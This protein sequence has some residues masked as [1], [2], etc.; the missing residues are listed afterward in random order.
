MKNLTGILMGFMAWAVSVAA[1]AAEPTPAAKREIQY[2]FS[3]LEGSGCQFYRNGTW[4]SVNEASKHLRQKYQAMLD[5]GL[6]STA[7]SFID[8]GA[9]VSS[10]SGNPYQVRCAGQA[11]PENSATWFAAALARQRQS[12]K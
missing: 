6:I 5:R 4:Y 11:K 12:S 9:S 3:H 8:K 7:E 1:L 2:L 10:V